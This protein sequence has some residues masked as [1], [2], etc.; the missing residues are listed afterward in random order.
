LEHTVE[1][2]TTTTAKKGP[3]QTLM[4]MQHQYN[5]RTQST[6]DDQTIEASSIVSID[7][8]STRLCVLRR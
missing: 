5:G 3:G 4:R 2:I 8:H 7:G 1:E 6:V